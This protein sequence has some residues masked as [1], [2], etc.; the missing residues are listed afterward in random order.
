MSPEQ[1]VGLVSQGVTLVIT[2]VMIL[3]VPSLL[4]GLLVSIVQTATQ[5]Q[6]QTLSFL[7]RLIVTLLVL[8]FTGPWILR[9]IISLFQ[10][11]FQHIPGAIG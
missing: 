7:P 2:L 1:S 9:Q 5:I 3:I 11:I 8:V 10:G 6:E 4:V